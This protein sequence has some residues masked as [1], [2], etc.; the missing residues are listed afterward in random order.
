MTIKAKRWTIIT[1]ILIILSTL[2][3]LITFALVKPKKTIGFVVSTTASISSVNYVKEASG[4]QVYGSILEGLITPSP[5]G[6]MADKSDSLTT[7]I[8]VPKLTVKGCKIGKSTFDGF[9]SYPTSIYAISDLPELTYGMADKIYFSSDKDDP[10]TLGQK[11]KF[12]IRKGARWANGDI[13]SAEDFVQTLKY[14][15]NLK[16]GSTLIRTFRDAIP[17]KGVNELLVEQQ[18]YYDQ[19]GKFRDRFSD[20]SNYSKVFSVNGGVWTASNPKEPDSSFYAYPNAQHKSSSYLYYGMAK[21]QSSTSL[22]RQLGNEIFSSYQW[23]IY[24]FH[25]WNR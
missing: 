20:Y 6:V 14:A 16:N 23:K 17:L 22:Y 12:H 13:V 9:E 11:W 7:I 24:W 25:W 19:H 3:G 18:N 8:G 4:R 15:L 21:G 1:T 2:L 10:N 5:N